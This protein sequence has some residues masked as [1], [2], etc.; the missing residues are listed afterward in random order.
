M[1][2][3]QKFY[4]YMKAIRKNDLKIIGVFY[5]T[6]QFVTNINN[7]YGIDLSRKRILQVLNTTHS[8]KN[9]YFYTITQDGYNKYKNQSGMVTDII[10]NSH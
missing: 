7:I 6:D 1:K 4:K 3:K 10:L 8:T 2:V 5:N 9:M